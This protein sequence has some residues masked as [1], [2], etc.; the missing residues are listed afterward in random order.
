[1]TGILPYAEDFKRRML[2]AINS[3]RTNKSLN[4]IP[5]NDRLF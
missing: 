4:G 3:R 5:N 2:S 1:M